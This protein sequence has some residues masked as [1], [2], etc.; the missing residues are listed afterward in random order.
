MGNTPWVAIGDFN[1]IIFSSEKLGGRSGGKRCPVFGDFVD[2]AELHD[3]G[4]QG[5]LFT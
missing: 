1:A 3:L 5:P 2:K 4:Y